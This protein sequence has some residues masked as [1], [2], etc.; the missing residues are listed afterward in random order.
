MLEKKVWKNEAGMLC[1]T[2]CQQAPKAQ[3]PAPAMALP[4]CCREQEARC[5]A[6]GLEV[7]GQLDKQGNC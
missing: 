3:S 2:R 7:Q 5:R 6:G 1:T 4:L